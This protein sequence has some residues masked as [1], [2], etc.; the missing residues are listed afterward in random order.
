MDHEYLYENNPEFRRLV[1]TV[2]DRFRGVPYE[3]QLRQL[4]EMMEWMGRVL[5]RNLTITHI[6]LCSDHDGP[7]DHNELD[8]RGLNEAFGE[9]L[10]IMDLVGALSTVFRSMAEGAFD[11][12]RPKSAEFLA[13]FDTALDM[14]EAI[15]TM[16]RQLP[17][18][19]GEGG[20]NE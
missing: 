12:G 4:A 17:D 2:V 3:V 18:D 1:D 19:D 9:M 16:T 10:H 13:G 14:R 20:D 15:E 6:A 8:Q 11:E 5:D 7:W